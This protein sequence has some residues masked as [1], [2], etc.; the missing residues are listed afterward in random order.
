MVGKMFLHNEMRQLLRP[1]HPDSDLAG[2]DTLEDPCCNKLCKNPR[3]RLRVVCGS[4]LLNRYCSE[5]CQKQD[6]ESHIP[7]CKV[8][9]RIASTVWLSWG[10]E[11]ANI[12]ETARTRSETMEKMLELMVEANEKDLNEEKWTKPVGLDDPLEETRHNYEMLAGKVV[13]MVLH[14]HLGAPHIAHEIMLST[15]PVV[16]IFSDG[17]QAMRDGYNTS[18]YAR[19]RADALK[20]L[21]LYE[22]KTSTIAALLRGVLM[23]SRWQMR[24][25]VIART[26]D[27]LKLQ[28]VG[29]RIVFVELVNLMTLQ[30]KYTTES[31]MMFRKF[32]AEYDLYYTVRKYWTSHKKAHEDSRLECIRG[33]F[34][35]TKEMY[36]PM[37]DLFNKCK[38]QLH[39]S[40]HS[41]HMQMI[42][43]DMVVKLKLFES[44]NALPM[45]RQTYMR[46]PPT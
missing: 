29:H 38:S 31:G 19:E 33:V 30:V 6:N 40:R 9:Q 17:M 42:L 3:V 10:D 37:L 44:G 8:I 12:L 36:A 46:L 2:F 22:H 24:E 5:E 43:D 18:K 7:L 23:D 11:M 13:V 21:E 35:R 39:S 45:G 26:Q 16:Q 14:L 25:N 4:C 15:E 27:M 32:Y 34:V 1:L 41:Q 20:I 28:V